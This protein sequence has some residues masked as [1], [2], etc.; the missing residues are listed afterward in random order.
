MGKWVALLRGV[1]V[2]GKNLIAMDRLRE[3]C[4]A[5]GLKDV[6]S[7]IQSGNLVFS[8]DGT[9]D[10]IA[11]QLHTILT[12]EFGVTTPILVLHATAIRQVLSSCP[13]A[14]SQGNLVHGYFCFSQPVLDDAVCESLR[15]ASE[16]LQVVDSVIWLH[17]PDGLRGS[18]LAARFETVSPGTIMTGRNLNT[19]RK[20]GEM[21]DGS[22][23][24]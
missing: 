8:S 7:Y 11:K 3:A 9:A 1:N 16:T 24:A 17:A 13:F 12:D 15:A 19:I 10:A 2:G 18:K 5:A 21:L 20:L 14:G 6:Q 23:P 4:T 22:G